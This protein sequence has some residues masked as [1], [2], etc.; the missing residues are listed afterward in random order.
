MSFILLGI[1]NSQAAGGFAGA[2]YVAGMGQN[3]TI[4]KFDFPS[5][6]RSLVSDGLGRSTTLM[7]SFANSGV[8]GY[9]AGGFAGSV[10]RTPDTI[11][12]INFPA[13]TV[14]NLGTGLSTGV[15]QA[16]GMANSGVAGYNSGGA[17]APSYSA[18]SFVDKFA[19]PSDSRTTLGTGLSTDKQ[20]HG[21][22]ANSGVAGYFGGGRA[23]SLTTVVEKFS[24]PADGRSILGTGLAV[25]TDSKA[26]MANS[27]VAGYFGGGTVS[28]GTTASI[29]KFAFPSDSRT[30]LAVGLS[31]AKTEI[32]AFA[33][34]GIAGYFGGGGVTTIDK[35]SFP[36]D[37]RSTLAIGLVGTAEGGS[38]LADSGTI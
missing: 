32:A 38:G 21:G 34:S 29:D 15:Y 2:G 5:D 8:A 23:P 31:T 20:Q 13:D 12:K 4:Q 18:L 16:A 26:G 14:S 36:S 3:T 7:S 30:T 37:S 17:S 9:F 19:F 24:F 1:L 25:A 11:A 27:G 35:F 33:H 28:G 6:T 10:P 22:M